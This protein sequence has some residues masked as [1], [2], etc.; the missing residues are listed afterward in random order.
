MTKP[1][2]VTDTLKIINAKIPLQAEKNLGHFRDGI[3]S[4][5]ILQIPWNPGQRSTRSRERKIKF[6]IMVEDGDYGDYKDGMPFNYVSSQTHTKTITIFKTLRKS[7]FQQPCKQFEKSTKVTQHLYQWLKNLKILVVVEQAP[8]ANI[9]R[10]A[11]VILCSVTCG[12]YFVYIIWESSLMLSFYF[13]FV[14][15]LVAFVP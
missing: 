9:Y 11:A 1:S 2:V 6:Q 10:D 14:L 3:V 13:N 12:S 15:S 7:K 4:L 5:L 8:K